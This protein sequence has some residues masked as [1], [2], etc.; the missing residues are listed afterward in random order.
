MT[1][2]LEAIGFEM[3]YPDFTWKYRATAEDFAAAETWAL[4][5]AEW[6]KQQG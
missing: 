2:R 4:Q 5:F 3:P 1:E 6:S